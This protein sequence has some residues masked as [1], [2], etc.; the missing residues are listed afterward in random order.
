[1]MN[2]IE[3]HIKIHWKCGGEKFKQFRIIIELDSQQRTQF[4]CRKHYIAENVTN[5]INSCKLC[6]PIPI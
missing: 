1:M 2:E 3:D 4:F 6:F 5:M